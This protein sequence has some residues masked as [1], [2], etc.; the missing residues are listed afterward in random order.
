LIE[1]A[2]IGTRGQAVDAEVY[3]HPA[4]RAVGR[5]AEKA[6]VGAMVEN[7]PNRGFPNAFRGRTP[8]SDPV[9]MPAFYSLTRRPIQR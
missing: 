2:S 7:D 3:E 5:I 4:R 1:G 9:F 6:L 8:K